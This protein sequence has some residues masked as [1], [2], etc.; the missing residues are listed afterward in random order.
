MMIENLFYT[1]HLDHQMDETLLNV[2]FFSFE[3]RDR[4]LPEIGL[5]AMGNVH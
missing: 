4:L 5:N 1:L 3:Q 2:T